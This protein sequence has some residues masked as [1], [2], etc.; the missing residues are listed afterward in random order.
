VAEQ[1]EQRDAVRAAG[2]RDVALDRVHGVRSAEVLGRWRMVIDMSAL[3]TRESVARAFGRLRNEGIID[4]EG[5]KVRIRDLTRLQDA[6]GG[7]AV[8]RNTQRAP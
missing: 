7:S 6:A 4:Q 8:L 5:A 3:I 2:L 1:V